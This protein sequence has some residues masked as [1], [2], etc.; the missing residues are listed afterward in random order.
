MSPPKNE[1]CVLKDDLTELIFV[2]DIGIFEFEELLQL[3][4]HTTN[5]LDVGPLIQDFVKAF[6]YVV[7]FPLPFFC[8]ISINL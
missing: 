5:E 1:M 8:I 3:Y 6:H 7:D 4:P 2:V